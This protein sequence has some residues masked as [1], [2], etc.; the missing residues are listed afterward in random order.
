[1]ITLRP[2]QEEGLNCIYKYFVDGGKGNPVVAWPTGTGKSVLPA[3]FIHRAMQ[4]WPDQRFLM[5]T[6]VKELIA[7]NLEVLRY[8][9]TNAPV[10]VYSAGLK[11][12]DVAFPIIFGGIQSM[13]KN[14]AAF[15]W[16]DIIFVDEAHL[17]SLEESSMYQT[18]INMMKLVNPHLKVIGMTATPW[19][20]GQGYITDGGLFTD[21]VQDLTGVDSFN[22]LIAEGYLSPL[23]P[24]RTNIM[25]DVSN[26]GMAKG[27][28]IASQLQSAVDKAEITFAGL[29]E[30]CELGHDRKSWLIFA[31]GIEHAEHIAA[32]LGSFGVECAAVHSKQKDGYNDAAILAFKEGRLRAI[33]NYGKLTTG[34]NHPGIDLIGMFR[35]TLSVPLWVQ[36]LGRGTRPAPGKENAL[37]LDFARNTPRLGPINDPTIPRRKGESL[38]DA[39]IKICDSCGVYNHAKVRYCC[40]CGN[41]FEFK[42]KIVAKAGTEE[43]LRS[44]F[45]IVE[46]FQ[47]V[48]VTYAKRE[49]KA[50]K[51]PYIQT[52]Y[53]CGMRAFKEN[54]FPEHG[55]YATVLFKNWWKQRHIVEPP[56]TTDEALQHISVLRAPKRIRVWVNKKWPEVV[57]TEY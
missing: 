42:V 30:L 18:F 43:L 38:G 12:K 48:Y 41:E 44:D 32:M 51:P 34:F 8:V 31:S 1:M 26:V 35:P 15:G 57:G 33:S 14:V 54:V 16:R 24:K 7:Q 37:V 4:N 28:F 29:R 5:I 23:V 27:E 47:V 21:I 17:I 3:V 25:L 36:M 53:F 49:G 40:N 6:H 50:G 22:R 39:P 45:P 55:G 2:Y 13:I 10:G 46:T 20:M 52:T 56:A 19:R 11:Q 9:W